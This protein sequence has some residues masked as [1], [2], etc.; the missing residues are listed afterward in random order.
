MLFFGVSGGS[1][2]WRH[3]GFHGYPWPIWIM[4]GWGL[5]LGFQYF[6]AYNGSKHDLAEEEFKKPKKL[7]KSNVV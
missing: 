4:L 5:G 6:D 3:T 1:L 7:K 2:P